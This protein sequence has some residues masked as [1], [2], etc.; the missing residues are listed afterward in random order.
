MIQYGLILLLWA[1]NMI[2]PYIY[3][4]GINLELHRCQCSD[5]EAEVP[6]LWPSD[7]KSQ[8]TGKD[9][10]AGKDWEQKEKGATEDE[11]GGW[12]H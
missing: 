12:H 10:E 9:T 11:M 5:A 7:G 4:F 3:L 6:I 1:L 8:L 2:I